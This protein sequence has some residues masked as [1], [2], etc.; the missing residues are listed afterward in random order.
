MNS[1]YT[2]FFRTLEMLGIVY[3]FNFAPS[4]EDWQKP[5]LDAG[6]NITSLA[7][8]VIIVGDTE[9]LFCN[10]PVGW[11]GDESVGPAGLFLLSR[12]KSTGEISP[13]RRF[14]RS[15]GCAP[16]FSDETNLEAI[17]GQYSAPWNTC[18][19]VT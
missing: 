13:R 14:I 17:Q 16:V 10:G 7:C 18:L 3:E 6:Y 8:T 9:Y 19:K 4:K 1:E 2:L 11:T 12:N 15:N 5:I